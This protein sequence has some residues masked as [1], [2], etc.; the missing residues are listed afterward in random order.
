MTSHEGDADGIEVKIIFPQEEHK[1]LEVVNIT[2]V[3]GD[4]ITVEEVKRQLLL[5][6][7][8]LNYQQYEM[9][10]G[11]ESNCEILNDTSL[12]T[13]YSMYLIPSTGYLTFQ[14][15]DSVSKT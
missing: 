12:I 8:I 2:D 5:T 1:K 7:N 11:D 3:N 13:N 9:L 10:G 14:L 15:K 4:D 6:R